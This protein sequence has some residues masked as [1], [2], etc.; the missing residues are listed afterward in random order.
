[1]AKKEIKQ[2]TGETIVDYLEDILK[3]LKLLNA[4]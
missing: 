2:G 3:E 4:K 1:M